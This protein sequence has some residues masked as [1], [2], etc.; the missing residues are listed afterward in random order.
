MK[1]KAIKKILKVAAKNGWVAMGY[2]K[3][4]KLYEVQYNS[5][6]YHLNLEQMYNRAYSNYKYWY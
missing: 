6:R 3:N 1:I 2:D 5:V 4:T